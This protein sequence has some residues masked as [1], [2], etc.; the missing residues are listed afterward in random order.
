MH[1]KETKQK[2]ARKL[3]GNKNALGF[4][5]TKKAKEKIRQ[6]NLGKKKAKR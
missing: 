6:W 5:Q 2:I 4:K 3:K 1:S